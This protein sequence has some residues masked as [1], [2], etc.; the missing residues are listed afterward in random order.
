MWSSSNNANAFSTSSFVSFSACHP[1]THAS[2]RTS[3]KQALVCF[4]QKW[5]L[6]LPLERATQGD[7]RSGAGMIQGSAYGG[8]ETRGQVLARS[9]QRRSM[10]WAGGREGVVMVVGWFGVTP[11]GIHHLLRHHSQELRVIDRACRREGRK[12]G[13]GGRRGAHRGHQGQKAL[14]VGQVHAAQHAPKRSRAKGDAGAP[15]R[16]LP[17]DQTPQGYHRPP[18]TYLKHVVH[19]QAKPRN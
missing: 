12:R 5:R 2:T 3:G 6:V 17:G 10:A 4:D 7:S 15:R 19:M 9:G 16:R 11:R 8:G 14:A 18:T 1:P 13:R